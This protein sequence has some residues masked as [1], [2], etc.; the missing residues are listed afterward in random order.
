MT[1][2]VGAYYTEIQ[3]PASATLT[4]SGTLNLQNDGNI[5]LTGGAGTTAIVNSGT[6][7]ATGS[8]GLV[9]IRKIGSEMDDL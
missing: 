4:N 9:L 2:I 1:S 3:L 6:L 7:E 5:Y 8:G